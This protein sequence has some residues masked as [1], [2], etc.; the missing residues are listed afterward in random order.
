MSTFFCL[1]SCPSLSDTLK[2][3]LKESLCVRPPLPLLDYGPGRDLDRDL[4]RDFI[5]V[6]GRGD[7][8]TTRVRSGE[9]KR[10]VGT[11]AYDP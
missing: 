6:R 5:H 4:H 3:H 10:D 9:G 2:E 1:V 8:E 11:S 7:R